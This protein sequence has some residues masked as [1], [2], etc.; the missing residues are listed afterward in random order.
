MQD[1]Y[2]G[3]GGKGFPLVLVHGFLGSSIM[4]EPQIDFFK[5]YFR[6]ITIDLPGFGKSKKAKP[7]NSIKSISNLILDCLEEKKINKF[8]LL[9]HSMG[10]MIVQEMAKKKGDK[11]SK[12]ICYSTGP[13]GEMPGRFESVE[14][15]REN[16]KKNGLEFMAKNIAKTWFVEG[17]KAKYFDICI[18]SGKQTSMEA[19]DNSLYAFKNWNG[20][21]TLKNIKNETLIIWGDQDK[22]YN[23][24]Q[25]QTL[26]KNIVNSKLVIFKN[27]AHNV[28]LEEPSKFNKII[29]DFL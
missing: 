10:G 18:E 6:V 4:W 7:H 27:C 1:I 26:E 9:G 8:H 22:S 20:V 21:D 14:E 11:I 16:L 3:D 12:L 23:L 19:V 17:D 25:V 5:D 28:H 15:S 13:R 2:I 29:M 24:E